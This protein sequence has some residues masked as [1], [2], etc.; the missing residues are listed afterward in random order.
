LLIQ[1]NLLYALLPD[2]NPSPNPKPNPHQVFDFLQ[3]PFDILLSIFLIHAFPYI[4]NT[5]HLYKYSGELTIS[6]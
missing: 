5:R 1:Q 4:T 3:R 2:F 6:S